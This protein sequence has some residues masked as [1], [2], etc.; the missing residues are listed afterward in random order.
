[1]TPFSFRQ[2]NRSFRNAR[3]GLLRALAME[4]SFR[5][6]L[7]VA[8]VVAGVILW[9]RI[10]RVE[11]AILILLIS[12]VLTLE[13]I[14]TVVERFVDIL[15]P[16]VHP[17]AGLIKDLMAAAVLIVSASALLIGVLILWPYFFPHH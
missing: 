5:V 3:E 9:L 14:N 1:M 12:S 4:H 16:R 8:I 6:H 17:Y 7:A 13:L 11:T 10:P 2:F 15:E